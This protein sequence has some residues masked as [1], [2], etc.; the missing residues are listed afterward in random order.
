MKKITV[1]LGLLIAFNA[2]HVVAQCLTD[3]VSD[4]YHAN[5]PEHADEIEKMEEQITHWKESRDQNVR[6]A[7]Y[8]I[9]VVFH[10]I[11][12]SGVENI[13]KEQF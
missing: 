4:Q 1:L 2:Q 12:S 9:P 10:V 11:H 13:S 3:Q 8:I 6:R 5:H 7:N